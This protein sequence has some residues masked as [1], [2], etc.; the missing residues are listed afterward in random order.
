M[1]IR[2]KIKAGANGECPT[3]ACNG[4]GTGNHNEKLARDGKQKGLTVKTGINAGPQVN[5]G[6]NTDY[7]PQSPR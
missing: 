7:R 1:K 3:G 6:C 2:T 5:S 4:G